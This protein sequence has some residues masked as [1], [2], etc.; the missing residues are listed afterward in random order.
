MERHLTQ[1]MVFHGSAMILLG[2]LAGLPFAFVLTGDLAGDPRAWRMAH[3]EGLL[4]GLLV[5]AAGS[6]MA[7]LVLDDGTKKLVCW[8]LIGMGYANLVASVLGAGFGV[9]GLSPAMPVSNIV[10][11]VLFMGAV[12]AVLL[13]VGLMMY[14]T[15]ASA[16]LPEA[17]GGDGRG[18]PMAVSER[19]GPQGGGGGGGR[20]RR[21]RRRRPSAQRGGN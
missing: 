16:P 2:L 14:G 6:V 10:V 13:A 17:P 4:N 8:S 1:R 9:R 21:R 12:V 19:G 3:L 15:R 11:Y 20:G 18:G 5:I 7:R